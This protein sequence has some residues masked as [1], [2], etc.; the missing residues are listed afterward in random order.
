MS[1]DN[2]ILK[3]LNITDTNIKIIDYYDHNDYFEVNAKLTY[4]PLRCPDC[5][6]NMIK[7][8]FK[9]TKHFLLS[10]NG[11]AVRLNLKKQRFSCDNC[12][13]T[14]LAHSPQLVPGK[15]ITVALINSIIQLAKDSL[16]VKEI[17]KI[18]S[19]SETTVSRTLY[20]NITYRQSAKVLP[21]NLCFDEFRSTGS[22]MSFICC[23]A[24]NDHKLVGLLSNRLNKSITDFFLNRYTVKERKQ[25]K[26]VTMD[27]NSQYQKIIHGLFPKAKIVIDRFHIVQ[28]VGRALDKARLLA[29]EGLEHFTREYKVLKSEWKIFHIKESELN[30]KDMK[31][32]PGL[33]EYTTQQNIVDLGLAQSENFKHSYDTYQTVLEAIRGKNIR[34]LRKAI[35]H[36]KKDGSP[37]DVA[38]HTLKKNLSYVLNS[39]KYSSYSNGPVEGINRKIKALKRGCFGFK[40]QTH[41]FMRIQLITA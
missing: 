6:F 7:Y 31:Y 41:F 5:G 1:Q 10:L 27:L 28:L 18:V 37:M 30:T 36:Y 20:G 8:G 23:D 32:Y 2:F 26:T 11:K 14:T 22:D 39:G 16:T 35:T 34:A 9:P 17:A 40:N 19:V 15:N 38:M 25:V 29:T 24:E 4:S 12:H 21:I 13:T 33:K 3:L